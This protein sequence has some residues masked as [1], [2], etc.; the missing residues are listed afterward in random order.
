MARLTLDAPVF[1]R[2]TEEHNQFI[3][4]ER[5]Q[6]SNREHLGKAFAERLRRQHSTLSDDGV[7]NLSDALVNVVFRYGDVATSGLKRYR[8]CMLVVHTVHDY[9]ELDIVSWYGEVKTQIFEVDLFNALEAS[10]L[11][12][13]LGKQI[14][15]VSSRTAT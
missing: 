6:V 14:N 15:R 4:R 12:P 8:E 13:K 10:Q 11:A 5:L 9:L 2:V 7:D 3:G 1:V